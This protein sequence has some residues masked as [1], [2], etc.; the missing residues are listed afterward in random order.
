MATDVASGTQAATIGV[1]HTLN[2]S[3]PANGTQVAK[4]V[5]N[6]MQNGDAV[7]IRSYDQTDGTNYFLELSV[8]AANAQAITIT[9]DVIVSTQNV[10]H[11]IEQTAG[12]GR[13][14]AWRVM[15][16]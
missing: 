15:D 10:R 13:S 8:S 7:T 5:L 3:V 14:Y 12:T 1:E 2:T 9:T 11:T 4:V 16:L 6:N